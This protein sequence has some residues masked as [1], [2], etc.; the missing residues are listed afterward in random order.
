MT[1]FNGIAYPI[2]KN[3]K[4]YYRNTTDVDQ[5]K[6]DLLQLLMTNFGERVMLPEYGTGLNELFF[7]PNDFTIEIRATELISDA[8]TA[9]EPRVS[10][11]D[12][13]VTSQ[14]DDT[15]LNS[16]DSK[17]NIEHILFIGISFRDPQDIQSIQ[18]LKLEL[19]LG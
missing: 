15:K 7:E 18:E 9:W 13:T 5:I 14:I 16:N 3:A 11:T 1:N 19:P 12:I 6:A 17:E 4:G 8:I 10:I 2:L